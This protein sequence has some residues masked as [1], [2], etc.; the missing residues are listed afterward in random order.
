MWFVQLTFA[1]I[2]GLQSANV[3]MTNYAYLISL[4]TF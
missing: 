4:L 2:V 1:I 3:V